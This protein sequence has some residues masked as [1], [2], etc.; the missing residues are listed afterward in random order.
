MHKIFQKK[1]TTMESLKKELES[2]PQLGSKESVREQILKEYKDLSGSKRKEFEAALDLWDKDEHEFLMCMLTSEEYDEYSKEYDE[3]T[4][5]METDQSKETL[6]TYHKMKSDFDEWMV[7]SDFYFMEK[8]SGNEKARQ[9]ALMWL[10]KFSY[11]GSQAALTG[12]LQ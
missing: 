11:Y 3:L 5:R 2:R 12:R 9:M 6:R 10:H 8:M 1:K 7:A 4:A